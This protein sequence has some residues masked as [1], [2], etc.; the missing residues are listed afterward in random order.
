MTKTPI[1]IVDDEIEITKSLARSLRDQF[2]I[3]TA[4][5]CHEAIQILEKKDI[6]VI[7]TDQR[8]PGMT[9]VELLAE[10]QR[11]RPQAVGILFSGYTDS[12][13]LIQALDLRNVQGFL[14]KPWSLERIQQV[15]RNAVHSYELITEEQET[16]RVS[17]ELIADLKSQVSDLRQL[18][19]SISMN[20]QEEK[21]T[22]S[23]LQ[24]SQQRNQQSREKAS[25]ERLSSSTTSLT[26]QT[27][28]TVSLKTNLPDSFQQ[29]VVQYGN[30]L[31]KAVEQRV[32]KVTSTISDDLRQMA[33]QL[34]FL[35]AG[36]RDVVDIHNEMIY[37]KVR[38]LSPGKSQIYLEEGQ[39]TILELMGYL[40]SFYQFYFSGSTKKIDQTVS[41]SE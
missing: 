16:R 28:G 41:S 34:G 14:A 29:I 27:Y 32:Y 5:T 11:I 26:A 33:D 7:L 18:L 30:I 12:S 36:A 8:I 31:E 2:N 15:L 10:A 19:N 40:L 24:K 3:F 17:E 39:I 25:M 21:P 1:L 13:A 20:D 6:A 35:R 4:N 37:T 23:E 38:D 22:E 9:G